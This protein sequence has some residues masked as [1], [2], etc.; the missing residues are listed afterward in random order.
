MMK[1]EE[2]NR[3]LSAA[4]QETEARGETFYPGPS[5]IHLAAFPP[6]EHWDDWIELDSLAWP[7][8]V[9]RRY[10]GSH[11]VLQLQVSLRTPGLY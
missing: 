5:R 8:K 11:H 10:D 9:E 4:R 7:R 3:R 2:L 1:S 6:K